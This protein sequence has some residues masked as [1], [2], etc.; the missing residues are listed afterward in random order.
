MEYKRLLKENNLTSKELAEVTGLHINTLTKLAKNTY[1][2]R[3]P[4]DF[5]LNL[6]KE[7]PYIDL[8]VYFPEYKELIEEEIKHNY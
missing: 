4:L 8:K 5:F 3:L 6:K 7:Y 2:A 1:N